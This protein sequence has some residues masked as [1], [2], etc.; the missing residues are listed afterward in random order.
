VRRT[1]G[2]KVWGAVTLLTGLVI[3][4]CSRMPTAP[5]VTGIANPD[6]VRSA[7]P[8]T[9]GAFS[10]A[11]AVTGLTGSESIDGAVGGQ[12]TV[13]RFT[14]VIPPG[15]FQGQATVSITV[16][17]SAVVHCQLGIDPP[18]ANHF[19]VPVTLRSDCSG[20]SALVASQL[21]QLWFDEQAGVWR[22][23]PGSAPDVVNFDVVAPLQH[24]S[25]YG[26]ID[27]GR[28]GW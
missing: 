25:D 15:A 22:E 11:S 4:G 2:V 26:V 9:T 10:I 28:A 17:D 21:A 7:K 8:T 5:V 13:G 19:A 16:P 18:T 27:E 12:L 24:F 14:L 3:A 20:T 1:D 6:F 23:V